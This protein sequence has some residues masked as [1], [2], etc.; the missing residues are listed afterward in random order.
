MYC[1]ESIDAVSRSYE[2]IPDAIEK[3]ITAKNV[4]PKVKEKGNGLK[5]KLATFDF[6]FTLMFMRII[7]TKTKILTK[8]L[9]EEELNIVDALTII[10]ATVENGLNAEIES[11]GA[12]GSN[13]Q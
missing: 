8:Q 3:I 4:D 1:L 6:L 5:K 7:M 11:M 2:V 10:D 9:Q 13:N 12:F